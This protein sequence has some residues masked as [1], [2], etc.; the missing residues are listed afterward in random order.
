M[1]GIAQCAERIQYRLAMWDHAPGHR[2]KSPMPPRQVVG[3]TDSELDT[4]SRGPLQRLRNALY[5][6]AAH[7]RMPLPAQDQTTARPYAELRACLP[8]S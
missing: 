4:W 3:L 5:Q 8:T 7:E 1:R 6:I 2:S